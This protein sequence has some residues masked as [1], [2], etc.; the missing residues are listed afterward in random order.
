MR[1]SPYALVVAAAGLWALLGV[2][3]T[4]L[5]DAG[6]APVEIAFWRASIGGLC[7]AVHAGVRRARP[8][9]RELPVQAGLGLVGVALFYV[10]LPAAI[11]AGGIGLS[12]VLLYTAPAFVLVTGWLTG[13]AV[14]P[15]S[16][17]LLGVTL[18][19][20][21]LVAGVGGSG[22]VGAG[23]AW[24][25]LSGATYA[26]H[27]LVERTGRAGD[28]VVRYAVAM[29]VGALALVPFVD[30]SGKGTRTWLLL[31]AIGVVS[32]YAPFLA[33][34]RA[35][36]RAD[37]ARASLVASVEPV[38]ATALGVAVYDESLRAV[39]VVGGVLVLAAAAMSA[40][41][42]SRDRRG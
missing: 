36:R 39:R 2:W 35:L 24:G 15:R 13:V 11:D 32:T 38:L 29:A 28:E 27:Y 19:G 23:V 21:A 42:G 18:V 4:E 10:A 37:P 25:L 22:R 41:E 5:L 9:R 20:I 33:L 16:V 31:L 14:R 26:T 7:F 30:W 3:A 6:L 12:W 40:Y 1:R 8:R 17:A 34:S